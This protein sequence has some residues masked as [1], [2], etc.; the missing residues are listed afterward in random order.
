MFSLS[1]FLLLPPLSERSL[2]VIIL[3]K[4]SQPISQQFDWGWPAAVRT[5]AAYLPGEQAPDV[6]VGVDAER[7]DEDE[8]DHR[9]R[10]QHPAQHI[11]HLTTAGSA[12][13]ARPRTSVSVSSAEN[14]QAP[15]LLLPSGG[16]ST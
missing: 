16:R 14:V 12:G 6:Q 15:S 9:P 10:L 13:S 2:F 5:A 1:D 4:S 7:H 8:E 3:D 11:R